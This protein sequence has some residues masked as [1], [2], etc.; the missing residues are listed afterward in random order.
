M[1]TISVVVPAYNGERTIL[2]TIKSIQQQT[3]SDFELIVINDGST[4]RTLERLATVEDPR[5]KVFSYEN[6]GLPVARNRGIARAMGEFIT[7]I[8]ADDLWTP[9]KLEL[10][11]A[12]LQQHPEAGVAYSW[13]LVMDEKGE[14]FYPGKSVSFEGNVYP[15]LLLSNFIASGSNVM[16]RREAITSVGEFDPTLRSCE[17]WDYWLRVAALWS[18]VVVPKY[19]ILYRQSSG[20]MSSKVEVMEK[21]LLIVHERAF[22][23][24]PPELQFLKNHGLANIYLFVTQL[25]LTHVSSATGAQ[26]AREKLQKAIRLH[27]Q[28]LLNKQALIFL[29]KL[30]LIG[31]LSP[32]IAGYILQ[33]LSKARAA[34]KPEAVV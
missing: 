27:P 33:K 8:D 6:G 22:Q 2:E 29:L 28:F 13:T 25:C 10:Q 32:K 14:S 17:D 7:F 15:Q 16:L 20:A 31:V 3:F 30:L 12:A 19:Q 9:D 23:A 4:D 26:Q 5:L 11:L 24:A 18:F 1:Q 34:N 21:N